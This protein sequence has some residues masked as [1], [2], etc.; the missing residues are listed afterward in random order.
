MHIL[1]RIFTQVFLIGHAETTTVGFS[2]EISHVF[3]FE[4]LT[5]LVL[6]MIPV[7]LFNPFVDFFIITPVYIGIIL[8]SPG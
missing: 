5:D 1:L 2:I 4:L 6:D 7:L 8:L 3:Y